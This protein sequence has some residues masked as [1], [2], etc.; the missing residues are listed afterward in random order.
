MREGCEEV[1]VHA[2]LL[3][4]DKETG[5]GGTR[6]LASAQPRQRSRRDRCKP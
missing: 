6:G 3:S 1:A 4:P 5:M 2:C